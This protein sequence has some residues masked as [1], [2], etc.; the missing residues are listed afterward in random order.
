MINYR[1]PLCQIYKLILAKNEQS[2]SENDLVQKT[3]AYEMQ[4]PSQFASKMELKEIVKQN[5]KNK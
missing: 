5:S 3:R 2:E 4:I 1:T